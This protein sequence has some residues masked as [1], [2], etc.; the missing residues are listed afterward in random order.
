VGVFGGACSSCL[1]WW[2]F[3]KFWSGRSFPCFHDLYYQSILHGYFF[4]A[5][6]DLTHLSAF[7]FCFLWFRFI[8]FLVLSI[9]LS[10]HFLLISSSLSQMNP[11]IELYP[12]LFRSGE[13]FLFLVHFFR[14]ILLYCLWCC[15][16]VP[17]YLSLPLHLPTSSPHPSGPRCSSYRP[18][19]PLG[20]ARIYTSAQGGMSM[21]FGE[22]L[23]VFRSFGYR[24]RLFFN[25][26]SRFHLQYL[27][28]LD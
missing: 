13:K 2:R 14:V 7:F 5:S 10:S 19:D 20:A 8:M 24:L 1:S 27:F 12:F 17:T 11:S 16:L 18:L 4:V 25:T 23:G 28:S 15:F 3:A 9:H 6:Y 21:F 22:R 26:Y